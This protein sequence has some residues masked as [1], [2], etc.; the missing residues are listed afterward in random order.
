MFHKGVLY[1]YDEESIGDNLFFPVTEESIL[2][3]DQS[4]KSTGMVWG[5]KDKMIL[6]LA[7][8]RQSKESVAEYKHKVRQFLTRFITGK[9]ITHIECEDTFTKGFYR[10][11]QTLAEMKGMFKDLRFQFN[12]KFTVTFRNNNS[13]KSKFVPYTKRYTKEDIKHECLRRF[14]YMNHRGIPQDMYDA[15][16]IFHAYIEHFA[17]KTIGSGSN[18]IEIVKV[19]RSMPR[20]R[21][22]VKTELIKAR[23]IED[24]L[25]KVDERLKLY[26]KS[27]G[28]GLFTYEPSLM[29]EENISALTRKSNKVWIGEVPENTVY[30]SSILWRLLEPLPANERIFVCGYR[31]SKANNI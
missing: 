18:K 13:W 16:G 20:G 5:T 11:D 4:S 10:A 17:P 6:P 1:E 8:K 30:Y 3:F 31:T 7:L 9:N 19:D 28:V 29:L 23:N 2:A 24:M 21:H 27:R 22:R 12:N 14:P 26:I 25:G 15:I